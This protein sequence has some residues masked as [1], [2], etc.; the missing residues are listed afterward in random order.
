MVA[1]RPGFQDFHPSGEPRVTHVEVLNLSQF[2]YWL[3]LARRGDK[4]TYW[5]GHLSAAREGAFSE[6]MAPADA[7]R[8][9]L[10]AEQMAEAAMAAYEGGL[11]TL[12]QRRHSLFGFEYMAV[13]R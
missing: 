12:T 11:V 6:V 2:Y 5:L 3:Q 9:A 8:Y 7:W 1:L 4:C 13:R 10:L